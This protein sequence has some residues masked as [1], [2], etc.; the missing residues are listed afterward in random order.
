MVAAAT[1]MISATVLAA[2][3]PKDATPLWMMPAAWPDHGQ[4]LRELITRDDEWAK[5][6]Q[7][8]RGVGYWA[9]LMDRYLTDDEIRQFFAK[10]KKWNLK[11]GFEIHSIKKD[12]PTAAA[13]FAQLETHMKRFEPLGA[14]VEWFAFDEPFYATR[15]VLLKPDSHAVNEVARLIEMIRK[16]Y[17]HAQIGDIEPYPALKIE[18]LKSF[19][20]QLN[21]RCAKIGVKSIDFLRLDV[22]W[23]GMY[24]HLGGSWAEVKKLEEWC[25]SQGMRFS[26][27]YWAAD[28][29]LL[30]R[31]KLA[32]DMTW[33]LGV[34]HQGNA[35]AIAGGRP[36]EYVLESW[37]QVPRHSVPETDMT[38][39]TGSVLDF[40]N[41]F[42]IRR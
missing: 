4:P 35:Y 31:I 17:P 7:V 8:I 2:D 22:D 25:R 32:D 33:Y 13:A 11:F 36:D 18:D 41:R 14:E 19:I 9:S 27:I 16:R 37:M 28:H 6:R 1:M 12:T 10:L 40:H 20:T 39:F 5:T 42:L 23:A 24:N 15:T 29:P 3:N 21:Q 30:E 38:T 34:M 26:L